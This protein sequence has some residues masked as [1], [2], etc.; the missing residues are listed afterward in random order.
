[1][2]DGGWLLSGATGRVVDDARAGLRTG[3]GHALRRRLC[4][5]RLAGRPPHAPR[6][7]HAC[8]PDAELQVTSCRWH[9]GYACNSEKFLKILFLRQRA[10]SA[11]VCV[12]QHIDTC[13]SG[14][15]SF[16]QT[17]PNDPDVERDGEGLSVVASVYDWRSVGH[18]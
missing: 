4:A 11:V 14:W 17:K 1:M 3:L 16:W 5:G 13:F 7:A 9:T 18:L 15:N 6:R 2:R 12:T 8:R 10:F